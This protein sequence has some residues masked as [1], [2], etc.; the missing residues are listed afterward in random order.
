LWREEVPRVNTYEYFQGR[1]G[2][3]IH[4]KLSIPEFIVVTTILISGF[5]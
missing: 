3:G 4:T 1:K 2:L 5:A